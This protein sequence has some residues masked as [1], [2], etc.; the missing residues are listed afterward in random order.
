MRNKGVGANVETTPIE[1]E[2]DLSFEETSQLE[3]ISTQVISQSE[4][5]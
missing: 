5:D 2:K 1:E 3:E 4:A